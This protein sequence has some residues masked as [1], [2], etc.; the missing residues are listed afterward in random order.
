MKKTDLDW[1]EE[2][3]ENWNRTFIKNLVDT[4]ITDGPHSSPTLID[5]G[6]PF[7]SVESIQDS[8][9]DFSKKDKK[10]DK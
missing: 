2:L 10:E 3:P 5:N 7:L 1:V 9:I 6:I 8:K 4:K